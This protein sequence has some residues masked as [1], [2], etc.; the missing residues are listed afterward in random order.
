MLQWYQVEAVF[1]QSVLFLTVPPSFH[2]VVRY[3]HILQYIK[4]KI[5]WWQHIYHKNIIIVSV[6]IWKS[7]RSFCTVCVSTCIYVFMRC[8]WWCDG[9]A[10]CCDCSEI[11]LFLNMHSQIFS[12][13]YDDHRE[14]I[15]VTR[16]LIYTVGLNC[17]WVNQIS[18]QKK[19]KIVF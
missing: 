3:L 13:L 17:T 11:I 9:L 7:Y 6:F 4:Q 2:R 10:N 18:F 8:V 1:I 12:L 19:K 5:T 14:M 16:K 15:D